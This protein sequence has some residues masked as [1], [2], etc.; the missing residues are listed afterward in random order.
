MLRAVDVPGV[1]REQDHALRFGAIAVVEQLCDQRVVVFDDPRAAPH[2]DALAVGKVEQ[3][4]EGAVVAGK[5]ADG[6]VL[7]VAAI[8][9]KAERLVVDDLD[10][11]LR[12]A[13]ML[14]VGRVLGRHRREKR[15]VEF[16]DEG[17]KI[18]RHSVGKAGSILL[19]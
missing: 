9:G 6:D 16:G 2:L 7:A 4:Q 10:E 18:G 11:A 8:V 15:R 13:A 14:D 5:I 1:D 17:G 3:E 19:A 12:S